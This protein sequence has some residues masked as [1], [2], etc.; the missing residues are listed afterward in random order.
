[1]LGEPAT[2]KA[3]QVFL[4]V[5]RGLRGEDVQPVL[6]RKLRR[7]LVLQIA[8]GDG[9]VAAPDVL[10]E[11]EVLANVRNLVPL[12]CLVHDGRGVR[13]GRAFQVFELE[14]G[15]LGTVRQLQHGGVFER[16]PLST[17][18]ALSKG[19]D[20]ESEKDGGGEGGEA[21]FFRKAH[22]GRNSHFRRMTNRFCYSK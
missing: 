12:Q 18:G 15:G 16:V 20:G 5:D 4:A 6:L 3:L 11:R 8:R 10:G 14:D 2:R 21:S 7:D 1:M 9:G 13:A 19:G 17:S 22:R